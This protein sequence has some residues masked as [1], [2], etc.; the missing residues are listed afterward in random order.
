ML[1]EDLVPPSF[2]LQVKGRAGTARA[3]AEVH[4]YRWSQPQRQTFIDDRH[5]IDMVLSRRPP[6]AFGRFVG[7]HDAATRIGP[8]IFLPCDV[9]VETHWLPGEQ[10]SVCCAIDRELVPELADRGGCPA[11]RGCL[12]LDNDFARTAMARI[13]R[14][15]MF[16][17]FASD[18]FIECLCSAILFDFSARH[19]PG[20]APDPAPG[21]CLSRDQLRRVVDM[22]EADG[23]LPEV[24]DIAAACC[25]SP[26]HFARLFRSATGK[27]VARFAAERRMTRARTLLGQSPMMVKEIA[28]R[29]GFENA[30][31]FSA[32]FRRSTGLT[33]REYRSAHAQSD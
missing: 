33:P 13:A 11:A 2:N 10:D 22:V 20:A 29:C 23:A 12:D 19:D 4:R 5:C 14:E 1:S 32:A 6:R 7:S 25:M 31:A 9:P 18:L 16:P 26:R 17:G 8:L 24:A 15:V 30:A 3:R 27:S 28:W 21:G